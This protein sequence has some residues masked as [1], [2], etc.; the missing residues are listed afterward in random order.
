MSTST[1]NRGETRREGIVEALLAALLFGLSAPAGKELLGDVGPQLL[2]GLLYVGSGIGLASFWLLRRHHVEHAEAKL[3]RADAR[4]LAV[5]IGF[6]GVL[7]PLLLFTG[8][9][10]TPASTSSLLLNFETVFTALL[11][12]IVFGENANRRIV[13]GMI[14]IVVG[15]LILSYSGGGGLTGWLGPLSIIGACLC[16]A[17]DNNVTQ[18]ISGRD[19]MQIATL[20][21]LLAGTVNCALALGFGNSLPSLKISAIALL[22]GLL[23]YG[24]SLVLYIRALRALGTARTGNYFS[25]APFIGAA[26]SI[27]LWREPITISL[28]AAGLFMGAGLWLHLTERHAHWHTH[29]TLD[30]EHM[31]VHDEHHQ[32][33]HSPDDPPGEPHS[34][35]HHHDPIRHSHEHY[36][37]IHHRHRHRE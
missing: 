34:H 28:V 12:W 37:D 24:A 35:P 36:P 22:L 2:A 32:H 26:A 4:I 18:K 31:H 8:L 30:H 23:S 6:G 29:E 19:P 11:A 1:P 25:L 7:A 33:A 14:S 10:D 13:L 9:R 16:W 3:H 5:A 15:G 21:G 17:I 20:K 27:L